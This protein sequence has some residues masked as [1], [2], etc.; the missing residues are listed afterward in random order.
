[1]STTVGL[2]GRERVKGGMQ[3]G[4]EIQVKVEWTEE[5]LE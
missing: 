3:L 2:T 1:M 4:S 5:D